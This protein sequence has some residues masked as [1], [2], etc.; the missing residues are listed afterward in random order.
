MPD[1][2]LTPAPV[3]TTGRRAEAK[4]AARRPVASSIT[5]V[6]GD[7]GGDAPGDAFV[8][9]GSAR[10]AWDAGGRFWQDAAP[11]HPAWVVARRPTSACALDRVRSGRASRCGARRRHAPQ[12]RP[13][14]RRLTRRDLSHARTN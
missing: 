1:S 3:K 4:S 7:D 14:S 13:G 10:S 9:A 5:P 6:T 11:R 8:E 2:V 12:G